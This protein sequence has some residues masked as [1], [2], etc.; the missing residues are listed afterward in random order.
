M[1]SSSSVVLVINVFPHAVVRARQPSRLVV[2]GALRRA[3]STLGGVRR[4]MVRTEPTR[5][6][7][8]VVSGI[9][10]FIKLD[11]TGLMCVRATHQG[12]LQTRNSPECAMS[13][14]H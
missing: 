2:V 8:D 5:D 3:N 11:A 9:F 4:C 12:K 13:P 10:L 14:Y 1:V 6:G 7:W